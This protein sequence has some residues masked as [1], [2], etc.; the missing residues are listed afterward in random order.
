MV[1]RIWSLRCMDLNLLK[2]ANGLL[3][4]K[5]LTALETAYCFGNGLLHW[6]RL[7]A[8]ETAYCIG[9]GLLLWKWLI[10][11]KLVYPPLTSRRPYPGRRP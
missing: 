4:W 10:V 2:L 5:W 1:K 6:K 7:T 9:N 8:L 3:L 11:M